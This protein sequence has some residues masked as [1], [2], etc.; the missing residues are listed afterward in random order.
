MVFIDFSF[1]FLQI[2]SIDVHPVMILLTMNHECVGLCFINIVNIEL[3]C[4][5]CTPR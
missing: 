5:E 2:F 3:N 4:N 1:L